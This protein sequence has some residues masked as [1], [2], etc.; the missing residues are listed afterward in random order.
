MLKNL[1]HDEYLSSIKGTQIFIIQQHSWD[2]VASD[3][4][5]FVMPRCLVVNSYLNVNIEKN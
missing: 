4:N 3:Q 2:L 5:V 1:Q